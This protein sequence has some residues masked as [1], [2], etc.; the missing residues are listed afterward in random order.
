MVHKRLSIVVGALRLRYAVPFVLLLVA[1]Y[2]MGIH[3]WMANWGSTEAERQM[4][5]PGD[6]LNLD[7]IGQTTQALT[8]NAPTDVVWQWLAQVGQDRAGFYSYTWLENLIGSDIHNTNEIRPDWQKLAAGDGWRLL[9][10]DYLWGVGKDAV[11]RVLM[12]DPGRALVLEM[13]GA[14][15]LAPIDE[16][17]TRLILRAQSG[18]GNLVKTMVVDPVVFTMGR[19]MLLGLKARAEGRPDAPAALAAIAQLGWAA[20]G[21]TVAGLFLTQ[22][23]RRW[24]LALPIVAA[25]PAL[26]TS[27][28][29]QAALAA[30]IAVGITVLGFLIYGRRW[31]GS[32]LVIG[33]LV[34]LTLLLAPEAYTVIGLAFAVLL[35]AA[36]GATVASRSRAA[37]DAARRLAAPTP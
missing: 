13:W 37:D 9:S 2:W 28:D 14:Y 15:I 36:L 4:T 21:I 26:L 33:S 3:P 23:R 22:R 11:S 32:F 20:A 30:F 12:S 29:V 35:L 24:W 34:M 25:L 8:I 6:D 16:H 27:A 18:P 5:L 10:P 19:R 17:T 31:W 7:R 1:V